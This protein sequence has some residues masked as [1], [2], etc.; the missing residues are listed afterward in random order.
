MANP[1]SRTAY[2]TLG[3]RAWDAT[4]PK[5]ACGDTYARYFMNEEAQKIWEE[6]KTFSYPNISNASRHAIIDNYLRD[7]LK[8]IPDDT[9]LIVGAGFDTRAFRIGGGRWIEVDESPIISY[10]ESTLPSSK[11]PNPLTRVPIDFSGE[12]LREKLTPFTTTKRTHIVVE[13]VLMYL[14]HKDRKKL[15]QTLQESFPKHIVYCDLMRKSFFDRY[16]QEVH[17]KIR[18][19]GTTFVDMTE[20]PEG[21]FLDHGYKTISQVSIPLYAAQYGGLG[22]PVF[23]LKYFLKTLKNGYNICR[24][25]YGD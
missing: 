15:M 19:L 14:Q 5:P 16:S 20:Y 17:Q 6:F 2:Y 3:V 25:Q 21:E 10:K 4:R 1:I 18:G 22:I 8:E 23:V 9:I 24:F 7:G 13:G 12:S 11:A